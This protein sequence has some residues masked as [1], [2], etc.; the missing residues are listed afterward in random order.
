MTL[1]LRNAKTLNN[2]SHTHVARQ[3]NDHQWEVTSGASGNVYTIT[4]QAGV[5]TCSCNWGTHRSHLNQWA[6]GCSH[7]Q[8][9]AELVAQGNG[10]HT[11]AWSTKE[12]AQRQHRSTLDTKDG[13]ILT[14]RKVN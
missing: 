5:Y 4:R 10:Y 1:A 9:V 12:D 2:K 11:S 8:A 13:I 7:V 6:S 3:I 14:A